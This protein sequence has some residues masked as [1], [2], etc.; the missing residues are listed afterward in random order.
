MNILLKA[1]VVNTRTQ[2]IVPKSWSSDLLLEKYYSETDILGQL[3]A[4]PDRRLLE[5]LKLRS[6]KGSVVMAAIL[7]ERNLKRA[8]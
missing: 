2:E 8:I 7:T 5:L 4:N 1:G 3:K 6:I